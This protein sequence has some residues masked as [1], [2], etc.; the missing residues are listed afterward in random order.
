MSYK[1]KRKIAEMAV[2]LGVIIAYC[3]YA[4]GKYHQGLAGLNDLKFWAGT[5]LVFIGISIGVI[6]VIE[7]LFHIGYA[8][9]I[10]VRERE[11]DGKKIG[12][13]I[14]ASMVEDEM[15]KLIEF[16]SLRIGYAITGFGILAGLVSLV[17]NAPPAVMLN[18]LYLCCFLGSLAEGFVSL[19]YY[20]KGVKNG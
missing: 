11:A 14:E 8:V 1:E 5:M 3:I 17:L 2:G 4:L 20:R 19:Y 7:I 6:V 12:R 10:A 13:S 9:G 16:K 18:L 15:D